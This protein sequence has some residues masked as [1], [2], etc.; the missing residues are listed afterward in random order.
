MAN[1]KT[2]ILV[3]V[4]VVLTL[5]LAPRLRALPGVSKIPTF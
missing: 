4:V 1:K 3:A 2:I 5:A